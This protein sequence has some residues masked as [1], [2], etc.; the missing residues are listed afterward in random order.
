MEG[1]DAAEDEDEWVGDSP[2]M[3]I[4]GDMEVREL[5]FDWILVVFSKRWYP[6]GSACG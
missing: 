6:I 3:A 5:L 1:V 2:T 4:G